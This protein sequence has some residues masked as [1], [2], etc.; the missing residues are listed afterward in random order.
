MKCLLSQ[1]CIDPWCAR[2]LTMGN[3]SMLSDVLRVMLGEKENDES[4]S[5]K[6]CSSQCFFR[7]GE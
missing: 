1:I 3:S 6:V 2:T 4:T 5:E 7:G